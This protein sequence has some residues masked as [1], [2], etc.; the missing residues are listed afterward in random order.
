MLGRTGVIIVA[1]VDGELA[2][3]RALELAERGDEAVAVWVG[4][5]ADTELAE[6]R[7]ELASRR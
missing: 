7:R 6:M 4:D 5:E 1:D 3:L 2:T